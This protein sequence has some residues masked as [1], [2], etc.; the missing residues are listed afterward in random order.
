MAALYP[1]WI[2]KIILYAPIYKG[3]ERQK[4]LSA[5]HKNTWVHAADDFQKLPNGQIDYSIA[6]EAV[7]ATYLS[8]CWR[9]DK[10]RSPNG[11]RRD[12]LQGVEVTLFDETKLTMPVLFIGGTKDPYLDWNA[13]ERAF[14]NLPQRNNSKM[15]K[16]DGA[17]HVLMLEKEYYHRFQKE[18][19]H[20]LRQ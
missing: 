8:N 7:V 2:H 4:V 16:I 17:S 9:Y 20:F 18:I 5:W 11:G 10:D 15:I 3:M 19:L 6:D 1:N 14:R 12:L 13:L